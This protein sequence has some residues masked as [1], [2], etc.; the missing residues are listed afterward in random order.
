MIFFLEW[1][2]P[3]CLAMNIISIVHVNAVKNLLMK[4][5][6][7]KVTTKAMMA[8]VMS[9][10][11]ILL[12]DTRR[13][14]GHIGCKL[15]ME[16]LHY[17]CEKYNLEVIQS[18]QKDELDRN[19]LEE[20]DAVILNGEGTMHHDKLPA[21]E[22]CNYLNSAQRRDKKTFIVNSVW[23]KNERL[24]DMVK[25]VDR[26]YVRESFSEAE[27]NFAKIKSRVI[28]DLALYKQPDFVER[29]VAPPATSGSCTFTD[30]VVSRYERLLKSLA[31][32][33]GCKYLYMCPK[34]PTLSLFDVE[35]ASLMITGR[36]HGM[37]L[38]LKYEVPFF[39]TPSN[40]HKIHGTLRDANLGHMLT[41]FPTER[42]IHRRWNELDIANAKEYVGA[43]QFKIE[44]MF[45]EIS[46][47]IHG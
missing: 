22:Y 14:V 8:K 42:T 18:V 29:N 35:S 15:V 36:F 37:I 17:L 27:L 21:I 43:A 23:E 16:N 33:T 2:L 44:N 24:N 46:E 28:P 11:V 47:V 5:L 13:N 10:K 19:K 25:S 40:T 9:K 3:K 45:K 31:D 41:T 38:A 34:L 1:L 26:I 20:C 4:N 7:A 12:N 30:C 32:K 39:C 6:T